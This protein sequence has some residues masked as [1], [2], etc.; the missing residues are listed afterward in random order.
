MKNTETMHLNM[1]KGKGLLSQT[2]S[3]K[4]SWGKASEEMRNPHHNS[5]QYQAG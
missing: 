1:K 5:C 2:S 3:A 4:V